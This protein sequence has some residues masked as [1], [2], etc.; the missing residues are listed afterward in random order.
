MIGIKEKFDMFP[1]SSHYAKLTV[2]YVTHLLHNWWMN[3]G[4]RKHVRIF[5]KL[6][7]PLFLFKK[8]LEKIK[9]KNLWCASYCTINMYFC[10]Q[11][12]CLQASAIGANELKHIW[13]IF[14]Q[15]LLLTLSM[16]C[17][18]SSIFLSLCFPPFFN[19]A[20]LDV[21]ASIMAPR[22]YEIMRVRESKVITIKTLGF[23]Q[24]HITHFKVWQ[25]NA[26]TGAQ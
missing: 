22:R 25:R 26:N 5:P 10:I 16:S 14:H 6:F 9:N 11:I 24:N 13:K 4:A 23:N 21:E 12:I 8:E 20:E 7:F 15:L 18:A 1:P 17:S 3:L 2:D 19:S